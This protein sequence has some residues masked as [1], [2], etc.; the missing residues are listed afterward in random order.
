[1]P[2]LVTDLGPTGNGYF[3]KPQSIDVQICREP[4]LSKVVYALIYNP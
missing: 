1:M 2:P 4:V 3:G